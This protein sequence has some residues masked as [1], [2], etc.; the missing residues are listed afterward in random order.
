MSDVKEIEKKIKSDVLTHYP[1]HVVRFASDPEAHDIISVELYDIPDCECKLAKDCVWE[2][3][4]RNEAE[5]DVMFVP[6]IFS[7]AKTQQYYSEYLACDDFD[8]ELTEKQLDLLVKAIDL[9]ADG[10]MQCKPFLFPHDEHFDDYGEPCRRSMLKD[11]LAEQ[12]DGR[13][14]STRLAA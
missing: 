2:I 11:L 12:S 4:D 9:S 7:H 6:S 5:G 10:N 14:Q 1:N 13:D 3:I 8:K